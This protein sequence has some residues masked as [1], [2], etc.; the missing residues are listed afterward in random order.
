MLIHVS[1]KGV[2]LHHMQL[3]NT[4]RKPYMGG[5]V[6]PSDLIMIT[7]KRKIQ[8][9]PYFIR[10]KRAELGYILLLNTNR[11]SYM[12]NPATPL[13]LTKKPSKSE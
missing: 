1:R 10:F 6:A 2:Q 9:Q 5:A 11:Q 3:L 8:G 4:N 7:L 12:G 13:D